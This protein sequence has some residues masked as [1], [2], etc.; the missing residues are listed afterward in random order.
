MC[1]AMCQLPNR[2]WFEAAYFNDVKALKTMQL[3]GLKETQ[4]SDFNAE[5]PIVCGL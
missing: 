1:F 5:P 2:E 3:F 4:N